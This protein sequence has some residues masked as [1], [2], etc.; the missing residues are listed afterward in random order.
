[1]AGTILRRARSHE[2]PSAVPL[3]RL[4]ALASFGELANLLLAGCGDRCPQALYGQLRRL[5]DGRNAAAHGRLPSLGEFAAIARDA[6]EAVR[7]LRV[8]L[9]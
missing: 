7:R 9:P 4:I 5:A 2:E 3:A 8:L 6:D 1:V